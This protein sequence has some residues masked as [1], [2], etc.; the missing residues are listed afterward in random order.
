[1]LTLF[2]SIVTV[3]GEPDVGGDWLKSWFSIGRITVT[4]KHKQKCCHTDISLKSPTITSTSVISI[5]VPDIVGP[6]CLIGLNQYWKLNMDNVIHCTYAIFWIKYF[7]THLPHL[8]SL[9]LISC[10]EAHKRSWTMA[11]SWKQE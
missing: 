11:N 10:L 6:E 4:Y 1:M 3:K 9:S 7:F 2:P 5:P 8:L